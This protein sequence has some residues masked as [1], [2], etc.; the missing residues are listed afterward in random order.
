MGELVKGIA[1]QKIVVV[2]SGGSF[3]QFKAQFLPPFLNDDSMMLLIHNLILLPTSGSQRYEYNKEK[4]DWQLTDKEA[5]PDY[6]K[7]KAKKLLKEII[8]SGLYEIPGNSKGEIVEDRD[9]QIT[10]SGC[11]QLASIEDKRAWDPDK[12]KREKIVSVLTPELPEASLLI[13]AYSSIDIL[14]KGFNKAVGLTRLLEKLRLQKHD[15]IFIGDGLF[16][17]GND[18]SVYEAGFETI[19][20]KGPK[21]TALILEKWIG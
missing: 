5:L 9:T 12:K 14:P 21:E 2:T 7:E 11:G 16:S 13:N 20:V 1:K 15:L 10:F 18:Y 8:A 19:P 17:G 4:K 6:V 3:K